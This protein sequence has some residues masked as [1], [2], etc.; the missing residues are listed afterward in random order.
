MVQQRSAVWPMF[1]RIAHRYD[2]LNR[3]LSGRQDVV[4]RKKLLQFIPNRKNIHLLDV[5]TGTGDVMLTALDGVQDV[6]KAVGL[7][8]SQEMLKQAQVKI[9]HKGYHSVATVEVANAEELPFEDESFDVVTI[10]FGIRNIPDYEKAIRDMFR[11]LNEGGRLL[12]LEFSLPK[13]PLIRWP[14]L[15]YFRYVLPWIGGLL[16]GDREAYAY[17]NQS[18][19]AFPYGERFADILKQSGFFSV[20]LKPLTFGIANIYCAEK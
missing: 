9:D 5:A 2:L 15:I 16:S 14:Y 8:M 18:V 19:E 12:I 13:N 10:A 6:Q 17:L 4:W 20:R 11:V 1:D 7:D 3:L